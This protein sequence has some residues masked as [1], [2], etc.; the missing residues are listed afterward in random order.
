MSLTSY[1]FPSGSSSFLLDKK[2]I[3]QISRVVNGISQ[4][5]FWEISVARR[6]GWGLIEGEGCFLRGMGVSAQ[7]KIFLI[8]GKVGGR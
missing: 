1:H 6:E 8:V 2:I 3:N 4:K 7:G 5:L